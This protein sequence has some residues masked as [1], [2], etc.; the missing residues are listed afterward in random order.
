MDLLAG[1]PVSQYASEGILSIA[2]IN[3]EWYFSEVIEPKMA[4]TFN[5][6]TG[7]LAHWQTDN[8]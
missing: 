2:A 3:R 7:S 4:H 8:V 5:W 1:V 6:H